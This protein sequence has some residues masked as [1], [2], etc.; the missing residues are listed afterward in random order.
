MEAVQG[1]P[2]PAT[3]EFPYQFPWKNIIGLMALFVFGAIV[4]TARALANESGLVLDEDLLDLSPAGATV[5]YWGMALFSVAMVGMAGW[6]AWVRITGPGK[7]VLTERCVVIP[8]YPFLRRT[9]SIEYWAISCLTV[10]EVWRQKLL[11]IAHPGGEV[12][13]GTSMLAG[14]QDFAE[15]VKLLQERMLRCPQ[16]RMDE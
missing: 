1:D 11:L 12:R 15:I 16:E 8:R 13:I 2:A 10:S 7:I 9:R 3:R 4:C 14:E 5:F 6:W